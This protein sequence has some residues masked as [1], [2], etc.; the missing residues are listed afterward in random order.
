MSALRGGIV[1]PSRETATP[2]RH[3]ARGLV[4]FAKDAEEAG[5]DSVWVGD[6]L[7]ARTRAEPLSILS[8]VAGDQ[9]RDVGDGRLD[10][11][12]APSSARRCAGRDGRPTVRGPARARARRGRHAAG[13]PPPIW[14]L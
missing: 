12:V 2:G 3:E 1:L 13:E 10:R 8:A 14:S 4:E 11:T 6:S 7:L 5:F 9:P